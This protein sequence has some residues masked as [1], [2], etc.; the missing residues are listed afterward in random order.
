M[1]SAAGGI[2]G[3]TGSAPIGLGRA[4]SG[5]EVKPDRRPCVSSCPR[6]DLVSVA[7]VRFS[8]KFRTPKDA[9]AALQDIGFVVQTTPYNNP[10]PTMN[11][12]PCLASTSAFVARNSTLAAAH[13]DAADFHTGLQAAL[14]DEIALG[15]I[16]CD[17]HAMLRYANEAAR[18]ELADERVLRLC[19]G[20]LRCASGRSAAL[21]A[22]LR[23][24]ATK[25][26]RQLLALTVAQDRLMVTLI[27][28]AAVNGAEPLLLLVLGQRGACS[29]LGLEM[30][31]GAYG[32]TFA[33]RRVLG[34]LVGDVSPRDIADA[35]GVSLATV[36]TQIAAI[37]TKFGVR[38]VEGVLIRA[39]EVPMVPSA[40]RCRRQQRLDDAALAPASKPSLAAWAAT[41][42]P[43]SSG[44]RH[45]ELQ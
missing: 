7:L 14:L 15:L 26:R 4:R 23:L 9:I 34:G 25:G 12:F 37:R 30:L 33:E 41:D 6:G 3:A 18:R 5:A 29:T 27:P 13:E 39:A 44:D 20:S 11:L 2:D 36:R 19:D 31:A 22:A 32:L 38:N 16:V 35:G 40:L 45:V 21:D 28:L 43:P 24:A 10:E 1:G 42:H 8:D 17:R